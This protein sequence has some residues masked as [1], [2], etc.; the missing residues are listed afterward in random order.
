MKITSVLA[1]AAAAILFAMPAASLTISGIGGVWSSSTPTVQGLGS[2]SIRWGTPARTSKSGY[3]F[4]H[5]STPFSVPEQTEFEIGTFTHHNFPITGTTLQAADLSVTFSIVGLN[6]PIT[7]TFSFAH[8]ETDNKPA[9]GIC[10]DGFRKGSGLNRGGCADHVTATLNLGQ[11]ELFVVGG[12]SYVLDVIGFRR[13]GQT[14]TDFWTREKKS[15]SA[16]LIAYFRAV[17]TPR[18]TEVPLPAAGLLLLGALSVLGA[19]RRRT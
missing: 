3:N 7:S 4:S 19:L 6:R 10:A 1:A 14:L 2:N 9:N 17:G 13:D 5:R 18:P 8:N 16:Q 15:N 12:V 11:T